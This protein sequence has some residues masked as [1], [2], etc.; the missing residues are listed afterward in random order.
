MIWE[1]RKLLVRVNDLIEGLLE[2]SVLEYYFGVYSL[3]ILISSPLRQDN[4][5]SFR[6]FYAGDY[7]YWKDF[8]TQ[9]SG[10]LVDLLLKYLSCQTTSS[11]KIRLQHDMENIMKHQESIIAKLPSKTGTSPAPIFSKRTNSK[12]Q[13]IVREWRDYDLEFWRKYGITKTW[14]EFGRIYPISHFF[15]GESRYVADKYA[16]CYLEFKDKE[17]SLKIY[18]PY[19]KRRKWFSNFNGSVWSLW[20]QAIRTPSDSLII[21]S[22]LKDALCLWCNLNIPSVALQGEGYLPKE[23][24]VNQIRRANTYILYD[25]DYTSPINV[26]RQNGQKLAALFNLKQ[27]EIP[28]LYLSKDPSDFYKN[29]GSSIFKTVMQSLIN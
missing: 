2:E 5:P 10:T 6:F 12:L 27:I 8:S 29:H 24:V 13:V 22:S 14:L 16:Y 11:L 1:G 20:E 3:P 26:G 18:Q 21:T 19:S 7:I 4:T 23:H 9:E 28:E 25:N 17:Q 15:I